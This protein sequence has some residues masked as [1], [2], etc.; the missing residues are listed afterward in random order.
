MTVTTPASESDLRAAAIQRLKKKQDFRAHLLVYVLVNAFLWAIWVLTDP[1]G[2][3]WPVY[4]MA[5]WG[6]GVVANAWDVYARRPISE[7]DVERELRRL[8]RH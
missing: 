7:E 2:H 3:P 4:P 6:I 5:G 1:G 8:R